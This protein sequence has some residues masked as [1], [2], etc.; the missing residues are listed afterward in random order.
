MAQKA[1][2]EVVVVATKALI[3]S[4][5]TL[6]LLA[7]LLTSAAV[8]PEERSDAMYHR[9]NGGGVTIDGPSILVRKNFAEKFSVSGNY[10]VDDISSASIDVVTIGASPDGYNEQRTEY[11]ISAD[12]LND[13]SIISAGYTNSDESDYTADTYFI[14]VSQ[15]F[16]GNMSNISFSYSRGDDEVSRNTDNTFSENADRNNYNISL[17]Q[18]LSPNLILG[19]SYNFITDEGYLN[20]PYR[21]YRYTDPNDPGNQLE[22]F[23]VYPNT[24]SSD[25][26]STRFMYY[27]PYRASISGEYR[28]FTDDWGI[29]ASNIKLGYTHTIGSDWVLDI[30]YRH[31][32]QDKADFYSDLFQSASQDPKDYRA[33][34][35]EL[36]TFTSDTIGIAISYQLPYKNRFLDRSSVSLQWDR[37]FFDYE[38]FNDLRDTTAALGEEDNYEFDADVV[39][40]FITIWY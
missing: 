28:Y 5:L 7:P 33:R 23:E 4:L 38:D 36:S 2:A 31:Y 18:I 26:V 11:S 8:L 14:A 39:K 22:G 37:I 3:R 27:L 30:S 20:N 1:V 9:Y 10:Y 17:S 25:A 16:F 12:Y 13:Q 6:A 29:D 34:D 21:Q 35:K 15:D 40:L 24:R 32:D 19:F